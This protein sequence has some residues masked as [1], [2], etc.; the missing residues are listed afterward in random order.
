MKKYRYNKFLLVICII[1]LLAFFSETSYASINIDTTKAY[2]KWSNQT[3]EEKDDSIEPIPFTTN[4]KTSIKRSTLNQELKA[5]ANELPEK[6]DLRDDIT[7]QVKNQQNTNQ[8]WAFS[9]TSIFETTIAKTKGRA[10]GKVIN[11]IV[12]ELLQ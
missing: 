5:L 6:Y 8:C 9:T 4:L 1:M 12:K 11:T 7:I 3:Q 10:D 2:Q